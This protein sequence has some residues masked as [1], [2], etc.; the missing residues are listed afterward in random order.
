MACTCTSVRPPRGSSPASPGAGLARTPGGPAA[1]AA[2]T[3]SGLGPSWTARPMS[4]P[5][6]QASVNCPPGWSACWKCAEAPVPV[7]PLSGFR[8]YDDLVIVESIAGE[9]QLADRAEIA[10]YEKFLA[11]LRD[12]A[13]YGAE[14]VAVITRVSAGIGTA[15]STS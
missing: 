12:A 14:A 8:L 2:A 10:R 15:G 9:Q 7:F 3:M 4:S 6:A 5:R 1:V 11:L 13:R